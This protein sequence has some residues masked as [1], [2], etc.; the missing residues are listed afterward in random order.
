MKGFLTISCEVCHN[1]FKSSDISMVS[2]LLFIIKI[3][4]KH[5]GRIRLPVMKKSDKE[6][7]ENELGGRKTLEENKLYA[8]LEGLH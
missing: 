4:Q 2:R 3:P 6:V 5:N 7:E 8:E 1:Y